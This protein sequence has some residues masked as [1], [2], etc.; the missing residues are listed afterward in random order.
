MD[1]TIVLRAHLELRQPE[2]LAIL[3]KRIN[4]LTPNRVGHFLVLVMRLCIVIRH[5]EDLFGSEAFQSTLSQSLESL[6]RRYLMTI[7]TVDIKLRWTIINN[8]DNMLVPNLIK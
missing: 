7:K 4:L 1:N 3:I 8:L 6:R 5:T 2:L